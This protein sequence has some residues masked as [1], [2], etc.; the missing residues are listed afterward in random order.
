VNRN[1][2]RVVVIG[3]SGFATFDA[4]RWVSDY[5]RVTDFPRQAR[6]TA[7]RIDAYRSK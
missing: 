2:K 7:I 6:E 4:I 3:S 1:L 5:W